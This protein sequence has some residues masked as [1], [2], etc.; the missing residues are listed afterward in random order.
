[1]LKARVARELT[2]E[3]VANGLGSPRNYFVRFGR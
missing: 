2:A 1:V 3:Q